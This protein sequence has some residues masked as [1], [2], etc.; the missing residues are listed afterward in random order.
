MKLGKPND[1]GN[2]RSIR[3]RAIERAIAQ[4]QFSAQGIK[5]S[6]AD[7][8]DE[9]TVLFL[10]GLGNEINLLRWSGLSRPVFKLV[11]MER[12]NC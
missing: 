11:K 10:K 1:F 3:I 12:F 5:K 9:H 7:R 4:Y 8:L 6:F 2:A